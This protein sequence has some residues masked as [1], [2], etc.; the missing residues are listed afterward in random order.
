MHGGTRES[1]E[2]KIYRRYV[3]K[4]RNRLTDTLIIEVVL[5]YNGSSGNISE[6]PD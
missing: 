2:S 3:V 1:A 6:M 4:E 5:H